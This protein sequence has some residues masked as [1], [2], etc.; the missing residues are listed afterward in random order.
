MPRV[1]ES[2]VVT[3]ATVAWDRFIR[4][5]VHQALRLYCAPSPQDLADIEEMTIRD[6]L[7]AWQEIIHVCH[8][9]QVQGL[10]PG[11]L[12]ELAT[13]DI[14][15][16]PMPPPIC[17]DFTVL[18]LAMAGDLAVDCRSS[19]S[20]RPQADRAGAQA[21][22]AVQPVALVLHLYEGLHQC[23]GLLTSV[24]GVLRTSVTSG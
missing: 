12:Y 21:R 18:R 2:P 14:P 20:F 9:D 8:L 22:A 1:T 11:Q 4:N 23:A 3:E 24:T 10:S 6:V 5:L 13:R 19:A 17:D 16:H 15:D 7:M